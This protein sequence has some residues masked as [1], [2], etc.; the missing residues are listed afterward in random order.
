EGERRQRQRRAVEV[1]DEIGAIDTE[2][3]TNLLLHRRADVLEQRSGDGDRYPERHISSPG[4][5]MVS[6]RRRL[7]P[8]FSPCDKN[9]R[10]PSQALRA[11]LDSPACGGP[12]QSA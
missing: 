6:T 11:H 4:Q 7:P 5:Y 12:A 3:A 10:M 9:C 8:R 1:T 2:N